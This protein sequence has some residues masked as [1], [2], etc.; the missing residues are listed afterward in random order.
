MSAPSKRLVVLT[1]YN[2]PALPL[3]E[4]KH[5]LRQKLREIFRVMLMNL[6]VSF[7]TSN[8]GRNTSNTSS[9]NLGEEKNA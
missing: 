2:F 5:L 4:A 7:Q 9:V 3:A 6:Y 1:Q 8:I